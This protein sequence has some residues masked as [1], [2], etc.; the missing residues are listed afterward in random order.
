[1][2][3]TG[4]WRGPT[5]RAVRWQLELGDEVVARID[6]DDYYFPFTY[7][8]LVDSPAFERFRLY[9]TDDNDWPE[10]DPQLEALCGEVHD[11]SGFLLREMT[12]GVAYRGVCLNHDGGE[13]VWFRHGA[14]V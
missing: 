13:V 4:R 14:P 7:G 3:E 9:F 12:T 8:R 11:R 10:D 5:G 2:E 6:A 1:M